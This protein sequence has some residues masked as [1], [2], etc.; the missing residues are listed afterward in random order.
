MLLHGGLCFLEQLKVWQHHPMTVQTVDSRHS[1]QT[2]FSA[3]SIGKLS[4]SVFIYITHKSVSGFKFYLFMCLCRYNVLRLV[5]VIDGAKLH[6]KS[7]FDTA[8]G[9]SQLCRIKSKARFSECNKKRQVN[10]RFFQSAPQWRTQ[11]DMSVQNEFSRLC[12]LERMHWNH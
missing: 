8:P 11:R 9:S 4:M 10:E 12:A 2:G 7:S 6:I 1:H 3:K 5:F